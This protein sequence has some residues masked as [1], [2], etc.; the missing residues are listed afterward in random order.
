[1][2]GIGTK[3]I[4]IIAVVLLLLFGPKKIPELAKSIKEAIRHLQG[5]FKED[6]ASTKPPVTDTSTDKPDKN[7]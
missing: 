6:D 5:A 2:F 4:V 1:M 7:K 3:E